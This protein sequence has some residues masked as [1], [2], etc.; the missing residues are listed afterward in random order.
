MSLN[1]T[2]PKLS[3]IKYNFTIPSTQQT[4]KYRPFRAGEEKTLFIALDSKDPVVISNT[5]ADLLDACILEDNF[6]FENLTQADIELLFLTIRGKS[7]GEIIELN[8]ACDRFIPPTDRKYTEEE[9]KELEAN[10]KP[11]CKGIVPIDI[12]I[13]EIS[14]KDLIT[15]KKQKI[16]KV[17]EDVSLLMQYMNNKKLLKYI[18]D[19]RSINKLEDEHKLSNTELLTPVIAACVKSVINGEE[20]IEIDEIENSKEVF[21]F[22]DELPTGVYKKLSEFINKQPKIT[23]EKFAKCQLCGK[24]HQYKF[25]GFNDFFQ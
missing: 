5:I 13:E 2:L 19:Y 9:L 24:E 12:N 4:I 3:T 15:D 20:V 10:F 16:I 25:E 6:N 7:V 14:V 11:V 23:I 8:I 1:K 18:N 22:I 17:E 21:D